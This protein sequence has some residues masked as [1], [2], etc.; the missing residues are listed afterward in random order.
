MRVCS[1]HRRVDGI[2]INLLLLIFDYVTRARRHATR[3][4]VLM[5][6]PVLSWFSLFCILGS[7]VRGTWHG[8]I[9]LTRIVRT[10]LV[11]RFSNARRPAKWQNTGRTPR[12]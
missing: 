8:D 2:K 11:L 6:M 12:L 10:P 5:V 3:R 4:P 9:L 1:C 7:T